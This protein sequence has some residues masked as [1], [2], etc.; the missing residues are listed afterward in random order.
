M[1]LVICVYVLERGTP[2]VRGVWYNCNRESPFTHGKETT[3]Q[4]MHPIASLPVVD[5][6]FYAII[7]QAQN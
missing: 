2:T 3:Y 4:S 7:T 6:F 5:G 1:L